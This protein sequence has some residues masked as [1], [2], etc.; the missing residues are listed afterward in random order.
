MTDAGALPSVD[1]VKAVLAEMLDVEV[2]ATASP[3]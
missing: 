3:T 2:G 1:V